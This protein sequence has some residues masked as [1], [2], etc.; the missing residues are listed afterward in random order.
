MIAKRIITRGESDNLHL[1]QSFE[2]GLQF[3]TD[4]GFTYTRPFSQE[5]YGTLLLR[6]TGPFYIDIK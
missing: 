6:Y 1:A 5:T 3:L 4:K 2:N